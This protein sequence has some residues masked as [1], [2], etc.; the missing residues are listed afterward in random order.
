M[1]KIIFIALTLGMLSACHNNPYTTS[2]TVLLYPKCS[3]YKEV[4]QECATFNAPYARSPE[5]V[6]V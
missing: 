6:V 2:P 4:R 5:V 1:F 3:A